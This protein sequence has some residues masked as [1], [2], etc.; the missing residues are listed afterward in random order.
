M[1]RSRV[2]SGVCAVLLAVV[3]AAC[4]DST[5]ADDTATVNLFLTDAPSD[6]IELA[7]VDIGAVELL[8][9]AGGPIVLSEDGTDGPVNLL[10]LQGAA[11]AALARADIEAGT[12]TQLRLI[13]ESA[14][15]TLAPGYE[16]NGGGNSRPL[17]VPSGAQTGIKL[18]L[19]AEDGAGGLEIAPGEMALVLDF[20]VSRSFVIQGNPETPAGINGVH[21][22]PTLRVI[23]RDVAGTVS[24][25]VSSDVAAI[26]G[27]VVTAEPVDGTVLEPFQTGAATAVTDAEGAYTIFFLVPGDYEVSV[28]TGEGFASTPETITVS[29]A[30]SEDVTDVDFEIVG[31]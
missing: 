28:A 2:R 6:Y 19:R 29:V 8:G 4:G 25:S 14:S 31:G 16:F 11:T 21:F 20:D 26:E 10:D 7:M 1:E 22:Q 17:T 24:G 12:Y 27:V 30:E 3:A 5:G 9:G 13:V 18:N 23:V 15:V